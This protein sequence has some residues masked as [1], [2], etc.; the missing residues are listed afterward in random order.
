MFQKGGI[1][2][3]YIV[4]KFDPTY[5]SQQFKSNTAK[6]SK[7]LQE[8]D[9]IISLQTAY[10]TENGTTFNYEYYMKNHV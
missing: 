7:K 5:D 1:W 10:S 3:F 8:H 4:I 9:M 6:I 2:Y